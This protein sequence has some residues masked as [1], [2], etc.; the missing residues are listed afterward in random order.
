M[1]TV[2]VIFDTQTSDISFDTSAIGA[3]YCDF[4][5]ALERHGQTVDI[6]GLS[7]GADVRVNGE[8]VLEKAWPPPGVM[9]VS[10]DQDMLVTE[11][12]TN[13]PPDAECS[14]SVWVEN[15]NGKFTG[16]TSFTIP[17]PEQPYASWVWNTKTLIW[18]APV[19][20]PDDNKFYEWDEETQSWV[21]VTEN[22]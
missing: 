18:E 4:V 3:Y 19:P 15:A 13:F 11:R 20:Y 14:L 9:Y 21:E 5:A 1:S 16:Q 6:R 12:L 17:R 7:Y 8:L 22:V 10:T 2:K